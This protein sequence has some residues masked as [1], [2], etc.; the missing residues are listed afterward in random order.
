M[1]IFTKSVICLT[2]VAVGQGVFLYRKMKPHFEINLNEEFP[3]APYIEMGRLNDQ[4]YFNHATRDVEV[5]MRVSRTLF[6]EFHIDG[7]VKMSLTATIL[8]KEGSEEHLEK[9]LYAA[10]D[11]FMGIPLYLKLKRD[12]EN[13]GAATSYIDVERNG[14]LKAGVKYYVASSCYKH[15]GKN[16]FNICQIVDDQGKLVRTYRSR[17]VKVAWFMKTSKNITKSY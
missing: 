13:S 6:E 1:G 17:F 15:I 4:S 11:T 3:N 8:F 9:C 7:P 5:K 10:A 14:P 16:F 2:G 12:H